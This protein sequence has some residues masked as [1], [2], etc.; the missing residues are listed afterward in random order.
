VQQP[1]CRA[2]V[3]IAHW[4]GNEARCRHEFLGA[5]QDLQQQRIARIPV[6][7]ASDITTRHAQREIA[8]GG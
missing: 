2:A 3:E 7:H 4:I 8:R 6:A 5:G 1:R